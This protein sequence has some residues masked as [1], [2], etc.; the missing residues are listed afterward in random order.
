MLTLLVLWAL[1][2]KPIEVKV[3]LADGEEVAG[4]WKGVSGE[5]AIQVGG[6]TV[7]HDGVISITVTEE[8]PAPEAKKDVLRLA[9]AG[10]G[11]R[12]RQAGL[13]AGKLVSL[14]ENVFTLETDYGK[15]KVPR[16]L[17]RDVRLGVE[18]SKGAVEEDR[19]TD[20][21]DTTEGVMRGALTSIDADTVS[22]G[23]RKVERAKARLIMLKAAE[24]P[25]EA[26]TGLF[27][28]LQLKGGD[29]VPCVLRGLEGGALRVFCHAFGEATVP[30]DRVAK[31]TTIH[32]TTFMLGRLILANHQGLYEEEVLPTPNKQG[33]HDT[34]KVWSFQRQADI[35]QATAITRLEN[36]HIVAV[37]MYQGRVVVVAPKGTDKGDV[38]WKRDGLTQPTDAQ[39]LPNGNFLIVEQG[40]R[41]VSEYAAEGDAKWEWTP[42]DGVQPQAARRLANGNTV[43]L[44]TQ[45]I[46]ELNPAKEVVRSIALGDNIYAQ[47][48]EPLDN[49]NFLIVSANYGIVRELDGDGKTVWEK[50][51]LSQPVGVV[52]LDNGNTL[53]AEQHAQHAVTEWDPAGK[54]VK[55]IRPRQQY[56]TGMS[57]Y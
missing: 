35:Q 34:K 17:V 4:E 39:R 14:T 16:A 12:V 21:V 3:K 13:L 55:R 27:Y 25:P 29:D 51:G 28:R 9:P 54:A 23:D 41:K 52:R 10:S 40:A 22:M 57:V 33:A 36:G 6:Q 24:A 43:I 49:G 53:I 47:K 15:V 1:Q 46:L 2:D 26:S 11:M 19:A 31:L 56:L 8:A 20:A 5:G 18:Q 44:A 37:N 7:R 42:D 48:F 50:K 38:V 30:L 32:S 45:K